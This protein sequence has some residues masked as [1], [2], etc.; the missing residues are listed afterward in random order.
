MSEEGEREISQRFERFGDVGG[1]PDE[2]VRRFLVEPFCAP[3]VL[4]G[5]DLHLGE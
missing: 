3:R 4:D 1:E 2:I 5:M